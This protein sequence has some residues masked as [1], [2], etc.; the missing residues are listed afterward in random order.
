[1]GGGFRVVLFALLFGFLGALYASA[2]PRSRIVFN[3]F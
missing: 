2:S 1:V 3:D